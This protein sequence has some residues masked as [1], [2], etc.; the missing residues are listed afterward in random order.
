MIL[1]GNALLKSINKTQN[2]I[3]PQAKGFEADFYDSQGNPS[4]NI[5]L[6]GT[7]RIYVNDGSANGITIW[8]YP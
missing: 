2:R 6:G 5:P 8:S 1:L 3:A 7:G 4:T